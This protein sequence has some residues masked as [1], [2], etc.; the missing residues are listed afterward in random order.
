MFNVQVEGFEALKDELAPLW[1]IHHA[2]T[3]SAHGERLNPDWTLYIMMERM[4][5]AL[6]VTIREDGRLVA[7]WGGFLGPELNHYH[8][9][10]A[11]TLGFWVDPQ[12]RA[13]G[14]ALGSLGL[15]LFR[16][17]ERQLLAHGIVMWYTDLPFSRPYKGFLSAMGHRPISTYYAK[18]IGGPT[19]QQR[20]FPP[21]SPQSV[22]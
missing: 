12:K 16:A 4:G 21:P 1:N 9:F 7:Y 5:R 18:R 17:V 19:C 3:G 6:L 20:S 8:V 2:E 11:T 13:E 10:S 15:R 22:P 14:K